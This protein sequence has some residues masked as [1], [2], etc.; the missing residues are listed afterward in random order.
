MEC[1]KR[2]VSENQLKG[3]FLVPPHIFSWAA[4]LNVAHLA[5]DLR[6][7]SLLMLAFNVHYCIVTML[8]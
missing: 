6:T 8:S 5:R 3:G 4:E 1:C 7:N 2:R